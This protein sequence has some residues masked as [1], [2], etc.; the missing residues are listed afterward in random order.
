MSHGRVH[1]PQTWD[2]GYSLH[3]CGTLDTHPLHSKFLM[4][5]RRFT[6]LIHIFFADDQNYNISTVSDEIEE[7]KQR[8][9]QVETK[10]D[11]SSESCQFFTLV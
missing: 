10:L 1:P 5:N 8:L 9:I 3:G 4:K 6:D 7:L 11:R 2:L